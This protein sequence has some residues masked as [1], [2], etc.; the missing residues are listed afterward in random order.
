MQPISAFREFNSVYKNMDL[1]E[2]LRSKN[3]FMT[4]EHCIVLENMKIVERCGA[5]KIE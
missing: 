5:K 4:R 2:H 3:E 1:Y